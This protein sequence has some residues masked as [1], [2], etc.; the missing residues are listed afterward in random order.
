MSQPTHRHDTAHR[1][2]VPSDQLASGVPSVG[3]TP[4]YA[5]VYAAAWGYVGGWSSNPMTTQDDIIIGGVPS[6]GVAPPVRLGKGTDGQVLTVDPTTHHLLWATP[7]GGGVDSSLPITAITL[8]GTYNDWSPAAVATT[9]TFDIYASPSA[10]I[11]TGIDATGTTSGRRLTLL[12]R[13]GG[14]VTLTYLDAGSAATNQI[15][16]PGF[17]PF[18][19]PVGG[20]VILEYGATLLRWRVVSTVALSTTNPAAIGTAAPGT[21]SL[22]SKSDHVHATGAG[23]P[24]TQAFGDAA[25]IGTGPAAAM[26]DH[27][28]GMPAAPTT[29]ANDTIWAAAGD[30]AVGTGSHTAAKL[31]ITVPAAN[32][33]EVLG[34]VNG[35]TTATWK[36][37]HDATAPTTQ[38][39]GDAAA[40]GT[41]LT[42]SHRDHKHAMPNST[43][44]P[45]ADITI[46]AAGAAGTASTAAR[47]GHGHK[48]ATYSSNPAAL[49]TASPGTSGTAPARGDHVHPLSNKW[50]YVALGNSYIQAV[51]DASTTAASIAATHCAEMTALPATGLVAV[52]V[53]LICGVSV[54]NAGNYMQVWDYGVTGNLGILL[55]GS[56]VAGYNVTM[57]GVVLTGGTNGRQIDYGIQRA[58]GTITYYIQVM[59][60]WT[61]L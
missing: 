46:D 55:Y 4:T 14:T 23:T 33:L 19:I 38:A 57:F 12:N 43:A 53:R 51:A 40:A 45:D 41:A 34:V 6:G 20:G 16:T 25:A 32:I 30:L 9:G 54:A 52:Q 44:G 3:M 22:T 5:G 24:V 58:A 27:K 56:S 50:R 18:I 36:A 26:T 29:I 21:S 8:S 7:A 31:A 15:L 11:I 59:G 48:V 49:G 42:A 13:A 1:G 17:A 60:Y 47:S 37:V 35:E 10:V 39:F 28:H 2:Y 61:T